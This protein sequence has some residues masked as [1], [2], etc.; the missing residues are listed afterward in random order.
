MKRRLFFIT[1][2]ALLAAVLASCS[3]NPESCEATVFAMDTVMSLKVF[4]KEAQAAVS[5]AEEKLYSLDALLSAAREDSEVSKINK[6][7]GSPVPASGPVIEQ[8]SAALEVSR[9]SGGAFDIS[10]LPLV[11]LWGFGSENPHVPSGEDIE[12]AREYVDYT[13]IE[14]SS[15][16][17]KLAD[18]MSIT[19]GAIAKGYASQA[20]TG[21]FKNR[22]ISSAI[23]SLGGNV[24]A[25]GTKP[26]GS[27]WRIAVQDPENAAGAAGILELSDMAAVTSGGYQRYFE[28]AGRIYHHIIDPKT[29]RPSESGLISVTIVC[30]NGMTADALSTALFVLGEDKAIEYW[31]DY[32]G[33]E[34]VFITDDARLLVT[35]G[36]RGSFI[37][38][39]VAYALEYVS[40]NGGSR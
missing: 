2:I 27:K 5:E 20:L 1:A 21:L 11:E 14:V 38:S 28:E 13:K 34:A 4:G 29:G 39:G 12:A 36:L 17:V 40:G 15:S 23:V 26:D 10:V 37:Q 9:R 16:S 24:Q 22:G 31:R 32:G 3:A 25:L 33:F 18:G 7:A 8:I 6:S 30:E 19:L 35:E